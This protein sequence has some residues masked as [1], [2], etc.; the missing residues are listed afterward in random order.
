MERS[1]APIADTGPGSDLHL[2]V[3]GAFAPIDGICFGQSRRMGRFRRFH[4]PGRMGVLLLVF[5][6]GMAPATPR[7]D[8]V[9]PIKY[10]VVIFQENHSFDGYFATYPLAANPPGQPSFRARPDT[11]FGERAYPEPARTE[12]QFIQS[13]P[14]R[15]DAG[16]YL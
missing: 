8:T 14:D 3:S 12:S 16:L 1:A 10:R 13:V 11:P 9:T 5:A 2:R 7:F 4:L 6:V 15:P